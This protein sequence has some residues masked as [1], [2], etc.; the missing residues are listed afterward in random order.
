MQ[1]DLFVQGYIKE[2]LPEID[3]ILLKMNTWQIQ[4]L[5]L[6]SFGVY[7]Y[8]YFKGQVQKTKCRNILILIKGKV[9]E[10]ILF[11]NFSLSYDIKLSSFFH[12]L[13]SCLCVY[14][15]RLFRITRQ[16]ITPKICYYLARLHFNNAHG[17]LFSPL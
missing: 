4:K 12:T 9:I 14:V 11:F 17:S 15:F 7:Y 10:V 2:Y 3:D 8:F 5:I 16:E 13:S 1:R 6:R